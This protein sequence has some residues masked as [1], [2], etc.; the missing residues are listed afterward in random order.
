MCDPIDGKFLDRR[1]PDHVCLRNLRLSA[2]IGNDAWNRRKAQPVVVSV[3]L[4]IDTREAASTD[5]IEKTVSY[6][7]MCKD[8]MQAVEE[9]TEGFPSI[10]EFNSHLY[11]LATEKHWGG[12]ALQTSTLLLKGSL[13]AEGGICL[14]SCTT[15]HPTDPWLATRSHKFDINGLKIPCIIGVNAHERLEKQL[16]VV[17]ITLYNYYQQSSVQNLTKTI[18]TVSL[19]YHFRSLV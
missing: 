4:S 5:D 15:Y 18:A 11:E 1:V 19:V 8:I 3:K 2:I 13:C 6:G 14:T 12:S 9:N 17:D 10:L 16:V 7:Q